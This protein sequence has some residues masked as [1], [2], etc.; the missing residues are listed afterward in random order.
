MVS[1]KE[2]IAAL[3]NNPMIS[4]T[5]SKEE[6]KELV[7]KRTI[8]SHVR[9]FSFRQTFEKVTHKD[10]RHA[11]FFV[12]WIAAE[13]KRTLFARVLSPA[14]FESPNNLLSTTTRVLPNDELCIMVHGD[15]DEDRSPSV[16]AF[17]LAAL[18]VEGSS[19]F[20]QH[21][22]KNFCLLENC[23][24]EEKQ[25]KILRAVLCEPLSDSERR[26]WRSYF[27]PELCTCFYLFTSSTDLFRIFDI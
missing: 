16:L 25:V 3:Q 22:L 11:V 14:E 27:S 4:G 23:S 20:F 8:F 18:N 19:K 12:S 2:G 5:V 24:F 21:R 1:I 17:P 7:S 10:R 15:E 13:G 26:R 9:S 6:A